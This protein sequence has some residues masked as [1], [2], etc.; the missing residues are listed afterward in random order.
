M[1][2]KVED[3]ERAW[4]VWPCPAFRRARRERKLRAK[5]YFHPGPVI[6]I[7]SDTPGAIVSGEVEG[8]RATRLMTSMPARKSAKRADNCGFRYF[9]GG[10]AENPHRHRIPNLYRLDSSFLSPCSYSL[11]PCLLGVSLLSSASLLSSSVLL[12]SVTG[13]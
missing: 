7:I 3:G 6:C 1:S 8:A 2:E 9:S 5:Q 4:K 13:D 11:A 10:L 12:V